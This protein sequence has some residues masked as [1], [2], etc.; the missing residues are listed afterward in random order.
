[1]NLG[2]LVFKYRAPTTLAM[3]SLPSREG[4]KHNYITMISTKPYLATLIEAGLNLVN[5]FRSFFIVA[6][7][8]TMSCLKI[9]YWIT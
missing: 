2:P 9:K 7:V 1:M 4:K 5:V 3:L 6:P 8:S